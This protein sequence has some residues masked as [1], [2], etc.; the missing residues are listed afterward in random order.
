MT[1]KWPKERMDH[2]NHIRKD[3]RWLNLRETTNQENNKNASK[4]KDNT[5]GVPGVY[6]AKHCN[7]WL[8]SI[9]NGGER[10]NLGGFTD[11]FEAVCAKMSANNKYGFHSNHGR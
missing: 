8:A 5:S 7:K 6:W 2:I 3:N 11:W 10:V 1:G 9:N 4:R